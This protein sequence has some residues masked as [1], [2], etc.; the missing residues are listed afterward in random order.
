[1]PQLCVSTEL[2]SSEWAAWVQAVGSILAL[3]LAY[4]LGS[5]Q[6][7]TALRA[8]HRAHVTSSAATCSAIAA[9]VEVA[10]DY[11]REIETKVTAPNAERRTYFT[12]DI[13]RR[14][15]AI[16][17]MFETIPTVAVTQGDLLPML[18]QARIAWS[19][20]EQN[21]EA[22]RDHYVSGR[23]ISSPAHQMRS[24][25]EQAAQLRALLQS[26]HTATNELLAE[27]HDA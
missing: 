22:M 12:G 20:V 25:I 19:I 2:S 26:L 18:V 7:R 5:R 17:S 1:M 21:A 8:E 16:R 14:T 23:E 15:A 3:F 11:L 27:A 13:L 6:T 4:W 9:V 24:L 10:L